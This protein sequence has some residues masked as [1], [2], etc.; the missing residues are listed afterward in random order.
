MVWEYFYFLGRGRHVY[1]RYIAMMLL[2]HD[3]IIGQFNVDV[4]RGSGFGDVLNRSRQWPS[5]GSTPTIYG[6]YFLG[7]GRHFYYRH[8]AMM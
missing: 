7:G 1:Y 4:G 6:F 2:R 8:I 3:L 5:M